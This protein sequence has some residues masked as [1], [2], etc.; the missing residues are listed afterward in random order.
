MLDDYLVIVDCV[1]DCDCGRLFSCEKINCVV[2]VGD[3]LVKYICDCGSLIMCAIIVLWLPKQSL[4]QDHHSPLIHQ[5]FSVMRHKRSSPIKN[6]YMSYK[7]E[8]WCKSYNTR[9]IGP[10][11]QI[12]GKYS[13]NIPNQ[14]LFLL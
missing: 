8:V 13:V 3:C 11:M 1:C 9:S 6:G 14:Q 4:L 2:I 7:N 10:S 12:D 5:S